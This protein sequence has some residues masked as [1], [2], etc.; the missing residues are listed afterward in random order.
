MEHSNKGSYES[1]SL[2]TFTC[3]SCCIGRSLYYVLTSLF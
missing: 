2:I 1:L 3:G